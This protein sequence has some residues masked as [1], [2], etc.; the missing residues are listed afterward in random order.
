MVRATVTAVPDGGGGV[1]P[2]EKRR[3]VEFMRLRS[4]TLFSAGRLAAVLAANVSDQLGGEKI[5]LEDFLQSEEYS[6]FRS[7]T[8]SATAPGN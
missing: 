5:V 8:S 3:R 7:K 6:S 1:R 4:S 2:G